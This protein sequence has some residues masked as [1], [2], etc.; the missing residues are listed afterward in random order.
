MTIEALSVTNFGTL[1]R[2]FRS[3]AHLTQNELAGLSA[4]SARTIRNLEAGRATS[5]RSDTVR[6]LADGLRLN[7]DSQTRLCL[8]AGQSPIGAALHAAQG[9]LPSWDAGHDR[10][11]YG[12]EQDLRSMLS[13]IHTG[14]SCLVSISGFGGVGKSRLAAALVREAEHTLRTQWLWLWLQ[15]AQRRRWSPRSGSGTRS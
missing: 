11:P 12:R 4:V 13:C 10:G 1:L 6:L 8:A 9:Q 14:I 7:A 3:R 15:R 2:N 5:P